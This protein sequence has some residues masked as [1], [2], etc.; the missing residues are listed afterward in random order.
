MVLVLF[1]VFALCIL[2]VL[3]TGAGAYKRLVERQQEAYAG[4]TVPQYI[5]TKVR[6]ADTQGGVRLG[7]FC[8]LE[9]LEFVK[10]L[11]TEEYVTRIYCYDGYL[12]ELFSE[13]SGQFEPRDGERILKAEQ[14]DFWL[15]NDRLTIS[16]TTQSG[17]K[18]E[19]TLSLRSAKGGTT[20]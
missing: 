5:V 20:K 7:E 10:W 13:V 12:R 18:I 14:V 11:G 1:G 15:Q 19:Q 17:E 16:V 8:G 2:A 4:R 3:L 6:Q 9:S